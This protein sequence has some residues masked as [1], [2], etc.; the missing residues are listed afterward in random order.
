MIQILLW[1]L[2]KIFKTSFQRDSS[3]RIYILYRFYEKVYFWPSHSRP[4]KYIKRP[5]R[6]EY[7]LTLDGSVYFRKN[8]VGTSLNI[9]KTKNVCFYTTEII[10]VI[11]LLLLLL[12]RWTA[13]GLR[14]RRANR[15]AANDARCGYRE[16]GGGRWRA[17]AVIFTGDCA[18]TTIYARVTCEVKEWFTQDRGFVFNL[19]KRRRRRIITKPINISN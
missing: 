5:S 15:L 3:I 1:R 17:I 10:I 16:G 8:F 7:Q 19:G 9:I 6:W 12:R 13:Y 2:N 4:T 14:T 11:T 18:T